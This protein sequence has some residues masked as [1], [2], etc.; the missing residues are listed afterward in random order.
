MKLPTKSWRIFFML[1]LL[2]TMLGCAN[3]TATQQRVLSGSA[4]GTAAGVGAAALI[5]GPLVAGAVT[6][7]A[8][9]AIGGIVVD[10]IEKSH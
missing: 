2:A 1:V 6:G 7:A 8:A 10:Q 3:M 9:G 4:L 5:G